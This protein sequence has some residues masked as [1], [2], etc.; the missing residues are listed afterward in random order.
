MINNHAN[1]QK[2]NFKKSSKTLK[3]RIVLAPLTH[4][5]SDDN[6]NLSKHEIAWLAKCSE[7]G[8]GMLITAATSVSQAG[9]SW[10]GQPGLNNDRQ[11]I[12]YTQIAKNAKSNNVITIVQLHHGGLRADPQFSHAQPVSPTSYKADKYHLNGVRELNSFE[13]EGLVSDFVKAAI[14]SY[15]SGFDG[16]EIH[17][18]FNFLLSN[19]SNPLL[20][21]RKDKWGGSFQNRNRIIFNIVESIRKKLP[22]D[23]I[24]GVRLSPENYAHYKGIEINEQIDLANELNRLDVDYIH[25]SLYDAFKK[26]NH[27]ENTNQTLLEWIK[28]R[29]NKNITLIIAGNVSSVEE[30]DK[31]IS[32]GADLV[33]IGQSAIGNPDWVNKTLAGQQLETTPYSK[34][35]LT[36]IGFTKQSIEY[37]QSISGLVV[38]D[39]VVTNFQTSGAL[40]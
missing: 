32:L 8:F 22:R 26:P 30:A 28:E 11:K 31:I 39:I 4:N 25:M 24:V 19:F 20:N 9:R 27:L 1:K 34:K 7:G 40:A 35:H 3:N 6:G 15:D 14:R 33:A 18:A 38:C 23:F 29:L 16:V 10:K 12:G 36:N 37:L 2:F 21:N 17:A 5:M 13:I